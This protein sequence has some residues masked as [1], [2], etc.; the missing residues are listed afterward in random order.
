MGE[1]HPAEKKVVVSFSP[2]AEPLGLTPVQRNKLIKVA[3]ARYN[4]STDTIKMSCESFETPA[5]NKRYLGDLVEVMLKEA[6]DASDTFEDVPFDFRH[7][8]PK[9]NYKFPLEWIVTPER[10]AEI[11]AA[12]ASANLP[13]LAVASTSAESLPAPSSD[14]NAEPVPIPVLAGNQAIVDGLMHTRDGPTQRAREARIKN[15]IV[16]EDRD[17]HDIRTRKERRALLEARAKDRS[18]MERKLGMVDQRARRKSKRPAVVM[19]PNERVMVE[20]GLVVGKK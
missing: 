15:L 19:L 5:Q 2:S 10:K 14:S 3:G 8:T 9:K 6:K 11:L 16:T 20:E 17:Y 13:S 18:E 1:D 4:P 7:H 12:R